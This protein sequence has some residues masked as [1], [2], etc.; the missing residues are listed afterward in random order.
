M[1]CRGVRNPMFS[2]GVAYQRGDWDAAIGHFQHAVLTDPPSALWGWG[3]GSLFHARA[4]GGRRDEALSLLPEIKE[5]L[6]RPAESSTG[7]RWMLSLFTIEGL[8]ALGM[9][10]EAGELY[11]LALSCLETGAVLRFD[12]RPM[13]TVAGIAAGARADWDAAEEHFEKAVEQMAPFRD[14]FES[15]EAQRFY[16]QMLLERDRPQ[17]RDRAVEMLESA[18]AGYARIGTPRH[19][20]M[21]QDLLQRSALASPSR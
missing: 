2:W 10:E 14:S 17:D 8:N 18:L 13:H 6:P 16:A 20:A 7:G 19:E 11:P 4:V 21:A 15:L 3:L 12:G 1:S 5:S 9:K